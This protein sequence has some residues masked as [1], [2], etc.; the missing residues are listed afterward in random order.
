MVF[1]DRFVENK[2]LSFD[3]YGELMV[4]R[5]TH[6]QQ[7]ADGRFFGRR[8]NCED[9]PLLPAWI[10]GQVLD[11]PKKIPYLLVW[12]S[13]SDDTI[14]EAVHVVPQSEIGFVEIRRQDGKCNCICTFSRPLRN[15]GRA[16]FLIC[17]FCQ[18]PR[19]GLYGWEAGGPFT[20]SVVSSGWGC[21][22]C[23]K[24]RYSSEGGALVIRGRGVVSQMFEST[25]S[26]YRSYRPELW[27]P[28]VFASTEEAIK[29]KI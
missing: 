20:S 21:R 11:D 28:D 7:G 2:D 26:S 14:Q 24:L 1:K 8:V 6:A 29:A 23:N 19:R 15:G 13:R 18:I 4:R 10:V 16:Q 27:Y 5:S 9:V 22:A 25:L 12:R 17:P 3:S